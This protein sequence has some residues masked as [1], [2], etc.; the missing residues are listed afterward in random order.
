[1]T[2]LEGALLS[3]LAGV[4]FGVAASFAAWFIIFRCLVPKI[5]FSAH[6]NKL[7]PYDPKVGVRY[8]IK[9]KNVG[10][11]AAI[12]VDVYSRLRVRCLSHAPE[13]SDT[14][15]VVTLNSDIMREP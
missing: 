10:Q 4:P 9:F 13:F 5:R 11:R 3:T 6:I 1:M 2:A 14:W 15:T 7:P 8:R 12:D